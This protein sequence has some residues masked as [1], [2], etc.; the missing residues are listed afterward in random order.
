MRGPSTPAKMEVPSSSTKS[1]SK[2]LTQKQRGILEVLK[3]DLAMRQC[4]SKSFL[5]TT[6]QATIQ[7]QQRHLQN[8]GSMTSNTCK[9]LMIYDKIKNKDKSKEPA[10]ILAFGKNKGHYFNKFLFCRKRQNFWQAL[11][12]IVP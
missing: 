2:A 1:K 8:Q 5:T 12:T 9:I 7:V 6:T 11:F 10:N 4:F 3:D